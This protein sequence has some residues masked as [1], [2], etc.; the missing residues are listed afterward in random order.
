MRIVPFGLVLA[1]FSCNQANPSLIKRHAALQQPKQ[2]LVPVRFAPDSWRHFLQHLP[3]K[4]GPIVDYKG[5][6]IPDQA[7]HVAIVD[8]DI[9]E[10]DL[11][12][13]ADALIRLRAEYLF[14]RKA[15]DKIGFHFSSGHYY[16]WK[17]YCRGLR[18]VVR[19]SQLRFTTVSPCQ[20]TYGFLRKYLNIVF[21]Y[22]GT[23]SL[24]S[25][26][27]PCDSF[28]VGTVIITPGY[29]GHC[30]IIIDEARKGTGEKVFR[31]VESFIPAQ[32]IYV[33]HNPYESDGGGWYRLKKNKV[34]HTASYTFRN[35]ALRT[36]E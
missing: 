36:F 30:S 6:I 25:E 31:L 12:Q 2:Q 8:F 11:Q 35:Y 1:A 17:D 13:C 16:S 21:S 33:L 27:K 7:K 34:I 23:A 28:A 15:Y 14:A 3:L 29:P 4:N 22:A 9:G 24:Y 32:S 19:G 20:Q 10:G 18:P 26:L 5:R